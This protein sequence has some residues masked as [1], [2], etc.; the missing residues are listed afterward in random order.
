MKQESWVECAY[1][2]ENLY[3]VCSLRE[4]HANDFY[5]ASVI[6]KDH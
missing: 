6:A 4:R 5:G 2:V 1:G 3:T